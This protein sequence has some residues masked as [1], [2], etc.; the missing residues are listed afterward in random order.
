LEAGARATGVI[1]PLP[2]DLDD[3]RRE[4][5][6]FSTAVLGVRPSMPD[7]SLGVGAPR[8]LPPLSGPPSGSRN[9][10]FSKQPTG[11]QPDEQLIINID[12]NHFWRSM[13]WRQRNI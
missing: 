7:A 3:G 10:L 11:P 5:L 13:C 2:E 1:W 6:L 4:M 12:I 8:E 9:G